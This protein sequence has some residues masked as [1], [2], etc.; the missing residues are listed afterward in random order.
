[1]PLIAFITNIP[2]PYREPVHEMVSDYFKGEY[3]VIY[4]SK[5]EPNRSWKFDYGNYNKIFLTENSSGYI[6]NNP[7]VWLKLNK[8]KP[9]VVITSGYNP[10]M[11]YA[12]IWC[13]LYGATHICFTDGTLKSE[14]SLSFLHRLIRKIVF[15]RTKAFI[16]PGKGSKALYESYKIPEEKIFTSHL[17]VQNSKFKSVALTEKKFSIMFSGQLVDR[18]MPL[19]FAKVANRI[20][21]KIGTC[22]VLVL[23]NGELKSE[24]IKFLTDH[25]ITYEYPGFIDQTMLPLYYSKT[26]VF[27]F[28]TKN[29]PWG[30]V[31]NEAMAAG[32]PVITCESAGVANDLVINNVNGYILPLDVEV[33]AD[34]V[35]KLL[36]DLNLYDNFSSKAF[37][38]VQNYNHQS[39]ANGIID[40]VNFSK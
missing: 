35:I 20:K 39:A 5:L 30:I 38:H 15:S 17:A 7:S 40:A 8:L 6:H 18:K 14:Q 34:H 25:N 16:G 23:G 1:M 11:L 32:L 19:F 33:W 2:A 27:L 26:K 22:P 13:M 4:C 37:S 10:T 29:D 9:K 12:F 3:T 31:V 24:L 28:P 36:N 21:E